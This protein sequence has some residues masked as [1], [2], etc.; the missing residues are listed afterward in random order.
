M[1]LGFSLLFDILHVFSSVA[2]LLIGVLAL[3]CEEEM[4]PNILSGESSGG[5]HFKLV[6][7]VT[8]PNV[9]VVPKVLG[10]HL[11]WFTLQGFG[12]TG[13]REAC[14]VVSVKNRFLRFSSL[15]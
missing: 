13:T 3:L 6:L 4:R 8:P 1:L 12:F 2:A 14:R 9:H 11:S 5:K 15:L 10:L 7:E